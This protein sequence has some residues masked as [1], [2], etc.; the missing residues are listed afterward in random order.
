MA[1]TLPTTAP[2]AGPVSEEGAAPSASAPNVAA[3]NP[4]A[5]QRHAQRAIGALLVRGVLG[6]VLAVVRQFI[7]LPLI[8]PGQ[9][10]LMRYV[11]NLGQYSRFFHAGFLSTLWVRFPGRQAAGDHDYCAAM[12]VA[13]WRQTLLG[14]ALFLPLVALLLRGT[15]IAPWLFGVVV[16][17]SA[18]P[19]LGDYVAISYQ[20]RGEFEALVQIDVIVSLVGFAALVG[21]TYAFR[22]PGLLIGATL[23]GVLRVALGQRY[24]FPP[25]ASPQSRAELR[26]NLVFGIRTWLGQ[27]AAHLA[28]TADVLLLGH[29]VGKEHATLGFYGLALTVAQFAARDV[30]AVTIV[31]QRQLQVAVGEHGGLGAPAVAQ[32]TERYLAI[33]SLVS[34]WLSAAVTVGAAVLLPPLFP[35]FAPA[36][37]LL[38]VLLAAAIIGCP[39]RYTRI[40]LMLA[41]RGP[42]LVTSSLVQ[43]GVLTAGMALT[44]YWLA[45]SI[46]GYTGA[47]LLATAVGATLELAMAYLAMGRGREGLRLLGRFALAVSPL[48]LLVFGTSS[49]WGRW[50]LVGSVLALV[51]LLALSFRVTFPGVPRGAARML[52]GILR[53]WGR[54]RQR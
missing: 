44:H 48:L 4:M 8:T 23:P 15:S 49:T 27:S 29:F 17:F 7:I 45:D 25:K 43:L 24:L 14:F 41:D 51:P 9:L 22:L 1:P 50:G 34:A 31:Q 19:L 53:G 20:S 11:L 40:V 35:R 39:L 33:D 28:V 3:R 16:L 38:A 52:G 6:Q 32:A 2:S 12:Q 46:W 36:V 21:L 13:A 37:P 47:R 10:G 54:R 26:E 18:F 42:L 5:D 30:T